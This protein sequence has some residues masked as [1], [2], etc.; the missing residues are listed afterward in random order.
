MHFTAFYRRYAELVT[1]YELLNKCQLLQGCRRQHTQ[2]LI[3]DVDMNA[4]LY[5]EVLGCPLVIMLSC[6]CH[7]TK[8]GLFYLLD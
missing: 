4:I 3:H 1:Y 2:M 6:V 7:V 8:H 5:K